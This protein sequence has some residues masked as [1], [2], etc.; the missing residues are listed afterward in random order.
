MAELPT[1]TVSL[2]FSDIE[3]STRLLE[4]LGDRYVEVL[5]DHQRL[6]RAAFARF[7]GREVGTEGDA[8][9]IAFG[10][11]SE[12]V[13]A[14]AAAQRALAAHPWPAGVVVRVRMGIHTGEPIVVGQDYAGLDVHRAARICSAA[15]GGQV[16]LSQPTRELLGGDLP[17]GVGL[18]D[19]GAHGLKDLPRPQRLFQLVVA[20]LP[21]DFPALRTV[22]SRPT[23]L[24]T[25]LTSFVGR[26]REVAAIRE[27]LAR[28]EVRL[29]TLSGPGGTG[30]TRLAVQIAG[31]LAGAFPDGVCFAPLASVS[32]PELVLPTIAQALGVRGAKGGSLLD[33]VAEQVGDR[34]QLLVVDNFEQVLAAAPVVVELLAACLQLEVLVTSRAALQVSGEHAYPVPPLSLPNHTHAAVPDEVTSSEAVRLFVE[35]AQ[36]ADPEFAV[37]DANAPVLAEICRRLDGLPLAI[38]LAAARSR[39]LPPQAL[40]ARL[41][42][43]LRLLRGGSRDLPTRQQTLRATIDWSYALLEADQQTLLARLAVFAGGCML[44]AAEVVCDLNGGLDVLAGLEA[45][46]NKNLLQPRDDVEGERRVVL[47]ETMREYAQ[48]RL[49]ERDETETVARR[50]ADYFLQLAEQAEP[51]LL[52]PRQGAWY[53]RLEADLDNFRAALA[54]LLAHEDAEAAAR[55]A[56][57]L[58]PLWWSRGHSS[59]GLRWLDAALERRGSLASPA[60]AKALFAKASLLLETGGRL[61]QAD[62][63]L[64]ESLALFRMLKD[65]SWTV[66]ALSVLGWAMRRAGETDRGLALQEQA[67]ALGRE[68]TDRWSLA[69]A[70]NNLGFSLLRTGDHTRARLVLDES[71]VLFRALGEPEGTAFTLDGLALL[72]LAEG[73]GARAS[74]LLKEALALAR[75]I[76]HVSAIAAFLADFGT[77]ALYQGDGRLAATL[78][79][80]ALGFAMQLQDEFLTGECLWGMAA[81]AASSR[82]PVRAVRLWG[83]AAALNYAMYV[84][85]AAARTIEGR[86]LAPTR[87]TLGRAF[88]V[89][90]T[91]GQAMRREDAIAY[92]LANDDAAS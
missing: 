7:N 8:F 69:L 65:T 72:A 61:G 83:A 18:R 52:G 43:R 45:L 59:E 24:P 66:R 62:R 58:M 16:L 86:L 79:Q 88:Q 32:D 12:A 53:E 31:Q 71:L 40:L 81:V 70:L 21:A 42:S 78:F 64:E 25:Q 30:K 90:W 51:E 11:A 6:L 37:T 91:T 22:G 36:A 56:A 60:L 55:L 85:S 74:T 23:N 28:P 73:D 80:E 38:E 29:L 4:R 47:L 48:E 34:R 13:S 19:L 2:L 46:V 75:K 20:G 77:V 44:E 9:F 67:V 26:R 87:E 54:W 82:Q 89:E 49:S 92:A 57:T 5:A 41:E 63:L 17:S 39:L 1:G 50:H 15:H 68:Q 27:L 84:H 33:S 35:R 76:G 10:K 14:A 3:G